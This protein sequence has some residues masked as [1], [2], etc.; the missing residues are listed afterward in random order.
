MR[1]KDTAKRRSRR[2]LANVSFLSETLKAGF[3]IDGT[4][5][6]TPAV[7]TYGVGFDL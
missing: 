3:I 7:G 6:W 2:T 5:N 1:L 4:G